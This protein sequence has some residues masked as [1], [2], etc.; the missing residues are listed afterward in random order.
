MNFSITLDTRSNHRNINVIKL[1]CALLYNILF[2]FRGRR[3]FEFFFF[4]RL[5]RLMIKFPHADRFKK[6]M[7]TRSSVSAFNALIKFM[8]NFTHPFTEVHVCLILIR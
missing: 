8:I 1:I 3:E 6:I 4:R 2:N 5:V 7:N